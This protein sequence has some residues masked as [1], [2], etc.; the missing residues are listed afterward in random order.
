MSSDL[1]YFLIALMFV[2]TQAFTVNFF[3]KKINEMQVKITRLTSEVS[4]L[5]LTSPNRDN[6]SSDPSPKFNPTMMEGDLDLTFNGKRASVR[7]IFY[8]R[9]IS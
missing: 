9:K 7:A 8:P 6:S 1:V 5:R 3:L 2:G 4:L